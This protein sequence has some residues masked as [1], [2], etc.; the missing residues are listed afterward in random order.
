MCYGVGRR[1]E[2]LGRNEVALAPGDLPV[3]ETGIDTK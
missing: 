3:N 1:N 2:S